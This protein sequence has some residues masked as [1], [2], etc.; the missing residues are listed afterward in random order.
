MP[1]SISRL[2]QAKPDIKDGLTQPQRE[3]VADLLHYCM[4]A[5]N[6]IALVETRIIRDV[7]GTF[8]WD[9][10]I[11]FESFEARSIGAARA[12]KENAEQRKVF[13]DS[14]NQRLSSPHSRT[15]ALDVC[16]QLFVADGLNPKESALL[17][18]ISQLLK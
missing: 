14:I 10:N 8:T 13:L 18:R 1:S 17:T 16:K 2:F 4:Y 7:V 3:A 15:L 11:A 6:H 9:P 5:D 12:A